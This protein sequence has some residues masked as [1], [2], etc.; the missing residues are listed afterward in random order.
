RYRLSFPAQSNQLCS[1]TVKKPT[2][3]VGFFTSVVSA[4]PPHH[5]CYTGKTH[6]LVT[7]IT[8]EVSPDSANLRITRV[9]VIK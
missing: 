9:V 7:V 3:P 4:N 8:T 1:G 6:V 5:A 2:S